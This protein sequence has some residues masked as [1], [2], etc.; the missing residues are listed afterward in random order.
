MGKRMTPELQAKIQLWRQKA[1][2][3]DLTPEEM[4]EAIIALRAGRVGAQVASEASKR[5]KAVAE[6]PDADD[7]VKE[8]LG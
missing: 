1:I 5:K 3:G 6:I 8:L 2:A 4:A 7:L